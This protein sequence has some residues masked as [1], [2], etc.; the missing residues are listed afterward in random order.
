MSLL[1]DR[2]VSLAVRLEAAAAADASES[3]LVQGQVLVTAL[4]EAT[5]ELNA[6]EVLRNTFGFDFSPPLDLKLVTATTG[7]L[8][9]GLARH[10]AAA[11]QH[12]PAT[13][14]KDTVKAQRAAAQRWASRAW[15]DWFD[16]EAPNFAHATADRLQGKPELRR[17][18]QD[19]QQR[20]S[21]MRELNPLT[22]PDKLHREA[23]S[24]TPG[25]WPTRVADLDTQLGR[26]LEALESA[27]EK[28]TP[29]VREAL[30]RAGT[31]AGLPF[32]ALTD[33]LLQALRLAGV[34]EQLVVRRS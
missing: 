6:A 17:R 10:G 23:G 3:L 13:N 18:A 1:Y 2:A 21:R 26:A 33:E 19:L 9:A 16:R 14:L 7:A 34:G 28:Q 12:I 25:E 27:R 30:A 15:R 24:A 32:S 8:R 11:F 4:Q 20:L 29:I 31:V 5:T 22:E